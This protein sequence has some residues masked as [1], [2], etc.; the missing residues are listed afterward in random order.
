M[1]CAAVDWERNV[2]LC[3]ELVKPRLKVSSTLMSGT[4]GDFSNTTYAVS[5]KPGSP[6]FDANSDASGISPFPSV[7]SGCFYW[8]LE[9]R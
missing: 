8:S 2:V 9:T 5:P 4:R 7:D 6:V 3:V 1:V